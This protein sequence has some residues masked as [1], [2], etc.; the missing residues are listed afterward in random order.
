M[1]RALERCKVLEEQFSYAAS[2]KQPADEES[3]ADRVA[4]GQ[5]SHPALAN[6]VLVMEFGRP[7][8]RAPSASPQDEAHKVIESRAPGIGSYSEFLGRLVLAIYPKGRI[9]ERFGAFGLEREA[10]HCR[11]GKGR[12]A[13][14]LTTV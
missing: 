7:R 1:E 14:K 11:S 8:T 10:L 5:P 4:F 9:A 3:L 2:P 13:K 12:Q 6:P